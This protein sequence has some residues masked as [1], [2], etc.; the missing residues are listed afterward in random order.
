MHR[1]AR[2]PAT[3]S[4]HLRAL[5]TA[6]VGLAAV[7]AHAAENPV[8]PPGPGP[9]HRR[10]DLLEADRRGL[11]RKHRCQEALRNHRPASSACGRPDRAGLSIGGQ[12]ARQEGDRSFSRS[13]Q[14]IAAAICDDG[15]SVR[16]RVRPDRRQPVRRSHAASIA[17][18]GRPIRPVREGSRDRCHPA[19]HPA[20]PA[21]CRDHSDRG[22]AAI[23]TGGLGQTGRRIAA[24][25]HP[26]DAG[27]PVHRL[28]ALPAA[29]TGDA[30]RPGGPEHSRSRRPR[31]GHAVEATPAHGFARIAIPAD[32]DPAGCLQESPD[33]DLQFGFGTL[34]PTDATA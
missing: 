6:V 24:G 7:A 25:R 12:P 34:M 30:T 26:G 13:L 3:H 19:V 21:Q 23:A 27:R 14:T 5:L 28:L 29:R 32:A 20:L 31:C 1:P 17:R 22:R 16:N 18:A 2:R 10:G 15:S 9:I 8:R 11:A 33:C 4:R